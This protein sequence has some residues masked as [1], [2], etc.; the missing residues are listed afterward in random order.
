M[1]KWWKTAQDYK[2]EGWTDWDLY[3]AEKEKVHYLLVL[4]GVLVVVAL[5]LSE[6]PFLSTLAEALLLLT[7]FSSGRY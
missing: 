4:L 6:I 3:L 7:G 2:N 1:S 5:A